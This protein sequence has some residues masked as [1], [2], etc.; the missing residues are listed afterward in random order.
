MRG[1]VVSI[2]ISLA[3]VLA[4]GCSQRVS[5][6]EDFAREGRERPLIRLQQAPPAA[7]GGT[8]SA[9]AM[10]GAAA[11]PVEPAA[12]SSSGEGTIRGTIEWPE[13]DEAVLSSGAILYLFVRPAGA[14]AGPPLAAQRIPPN[15][16]PMP[17]AIGPADAMSAAVDFPEQVTVEARLDRDGDAM[18]RGPDDWTARSEPI[19]PGSRGVVLV[20]SR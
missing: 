14:E 15:S 11:E 13:A 3:V 6:E 16:F 9:T 2:A 18:S 10:P 20:L 5:T 17:F 12:E 7:G 8:G 19:A 1:P 4:A